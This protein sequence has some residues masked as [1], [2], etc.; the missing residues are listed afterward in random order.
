[1]FFQSL[2]F[3]K[4]FLKHGSRSVN[5]K[6]VLAVILILASISVFFYMSGNISSGYQ[7]YDDHEI[8]RISHDL[9]SQPF[10]DVA[11]KWIENDLSIR[12]R[13]MYF[14]HRV[15]ETQIFGHDFKLLSI[16]TASLFAFTTIFFYFAFRKIGFSIIEAFA[17]L[18]LTFVGPQMTIWWRLGPNETIGMVFLSIA[19]YFMVNCKERYELN[20]FWFSLFLVFASL[21]KESFTVI[22]PAMIIFKIWYEIDNFEFGILEALR[23]NSMLLLPLLV[24]LINIYIIVFVVGTNQIEYAGV[25]SNIR[26]IIKGAIRILKDP[27]KQYLALTF[28]VFVVTSIGLGKKNILDLGKKMLMP[29]SVFILI[30]VPNLALYAKSGMQV[31]R[32]MLPSLVGFSFFVISLINETGKTAK[33]LRVIL[34]VAVFGFVANLSRTVLKSAQ[35]Y[36]AIGNQNNEFLLAVVENSTTSSELLLVLDPTSWDFEASMAIQSYIE[37]I[38]DIPLYGYAIYTPEDLKGKEHLVEVWE[39]W[40]KGKMFSDLESDPDMIIFLDESLVEIFFNESGLNRSTYAD[41]YYESD[42]IV[43]EMK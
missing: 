35:Y 28:G 33:W 4:I 32:Y 18:L 3:F 16:Y 29:F 13:P 25:D 1:M 20:T 10:F 40:F 34:L 27:L 12:Y 15:L 41:Y 17:S 19:F 11:H 26:G 5:K 39:V 24:M 37:L 14:F 2:S 22:I 23:K 42:Y 8:L 31:P 9:S 38:N 6:D 21:S 30:L 36:A 43:L 7:F